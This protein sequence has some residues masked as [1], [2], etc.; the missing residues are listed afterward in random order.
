MAEAE[1]ELGIRDAQLQSAA[2]QFERQQELLAQEG[3]DL[4]AQEAEM[5][6]EAEAA[7]REAAKLREQ[8]EARHGMADGLQAEVPLPPSFAKLALTTMLYCRAVQPR[9]LSPGP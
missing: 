9:A 5:R 7:E 8:A 3:N 1:T 6:A 4:D 2:A